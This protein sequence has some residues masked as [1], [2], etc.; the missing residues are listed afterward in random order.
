MTPLERALQKEVKEGRVVCR[1]HPKEE[2]YIYNYTKKTQIDRLWNET[3]K[4]AR[5]LI[6]DFKGNVVVRPFAKFFDQADNVPDE[7]CEIT[8]KLDG[9]LGI[10]YQVRDDVFIATRGSFDSEQAIEAN[11]ILQT[12]KSCGK[13][14]KEIL[15]SRPVKHVT[16]LFEIIYPEN[17][18]VVDYGSGR[19]LIFLDAIETDTGTSLSTEREHMRRLLPE[20]HSRVVFS[21][22]YNS[23][24]CK[25]AI[26]SYLS[27][28]NI[29]G[30][31]VSFPLSNV[32]W[33]I[34]AE[35]YVVAHK[36]K[37]QYTD[38]HIWKILSGKE[39]G[40]INQIIA[41]CVDDEQKKRIQDAISTMLS[42]FEIH[43]KY[44]E[45]VRNV[46]KDFGSQK[47]IALYLQSECPDIASCVFSALKGKDYSKM[48]W[49]RIEPKGEQDD[50]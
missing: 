26:A 43:R 4:L 17:R 7:P 29:E 27:Q 9:S 10:V 41:L 21:G 1:K 34:K 42:K 11:K 8:E 47:E 23:E 46:V 38:K 28:Q 6:L 13:T 40:D 15:L 48:I 31:V 2:L 16:Y 24:A 44:V 33:K 18:I 37:Y 30:L 25:E 35:P 39:D 49:D 22:W 45:E 12:Q 14:L 19:R 3:N 36:I 20:D 50:V 5:G 32:R